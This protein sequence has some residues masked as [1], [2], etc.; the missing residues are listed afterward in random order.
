VVALGYQGLKEALPPE[1][2]D[3]E[4]PGLRKALEEIWAEGKFNF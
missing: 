1:L 2:H 4:Y 3:R